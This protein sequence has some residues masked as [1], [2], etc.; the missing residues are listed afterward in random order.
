M[1]K[2]T[3]AAALL[4]GGM[5][6]LQTPSSAHGGVCYGPGGTPGPAGHCPMPSAGDLGPT[7]VGPAGASGTRAPVGPSIAGPVRPGTPGGST[8]ATMPVGP[9]LTVWSLWWEFSK[10]PYLNLKAHIHG[11]GLVSGSGDWFL[12]QGKTDTARDS[13]A[14]TREQIR[15]KVVPA[16][17][18]ALERE[19]NN[20][21]VTGCLIAL[22]KIGDA[23]TE[24]RTSEF[25]QVIKNF[26]ADS[27]QEI[28]ETAAVS[29]GILANDAS[30]PTLEALLKDTSEGRNLVGS[31][32][33]N[34][35]TRSFAAYGLGL[36]GARTVK[37]DKRQEIVRI[38]TE[39]I[40]TD[41]T[42]SRDLK[43]S[44]IIAMG[45]VRL[46]TIE[47]LPETAP[48]PYG[49]RVGQLEY[50]LA[51]LQ[52]DDNNF[53]VR[54]HCPTALARLLVDLPAE[55][56]EAWRMRIAADLTERASKNPHPRSISKEQIEVI[57]S[58][59][60]ALGL[61]GTNGKEDKAIRDVLAAVPRDIADQQSRN[62]SMIAMAKAG[63]TVGQEDID[64]G[65]AQ[66]SDFL[67]G[68]LSKGKSSIK[69]WAGLSIGVM[70]RELAKANVSS[71]HM[72][73]MAS[74]LRMALDEEKDKAKLGAYAVG[75]GIMRDIESSAILREKLQRVQD[76]EAR[77]YV[78]V[79]LGLINAREAVVDIQDIVKESKYRPGLLRQAAVGLGLLGD[80]E[81]VPD[82]MKMLS[83][84]KSLA[85]Q[86][87]IASALGSIGDARSIDPLVEMMENEDLTARA[88][89]F[90]AVAL[91]IVADKEPLPWNTKIGLDLN[92]RASTQTLVAGGA[93]ILDIL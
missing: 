66:A 21:I 17:L 22:A 39:T 83:E 25:E 2:L 49:S 72:A 44:C 42:K 71:A 62:F 82:L 4:A 32:Q 1:K 13:M 14:P 34:Y 55:R 58:S 79:A 12:G 84:S 52:D 46:E 19:T 7:S 54:A 78:A 20:D 23:N 18:A 40:E 28:S 48:R 24:S 64:S 65:I 90:A 37:E 31:S 26:L 47:P 75:V 38:L 76:D 93:G 67:L 43:V 89:A 86:A 27:N 88:R 50:L 41:D 6:G 73:A 45:L 63:G 61:I 81:L 15:Q 33:V 56:Y 8:T 87:A 92:Y 36:I 70:H 5:L 11:N 35:R 91:G 85:A 9:D 16:L 80:K 74:A 59:I 30:I 69:P 57:E 68:Q 77:G 29:L 51:F 3:L 60:L 10:Q 53:L